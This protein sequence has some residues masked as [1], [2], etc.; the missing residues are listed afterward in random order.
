MSNYPFIFGARG[1]GG[2][3]GSVSVAL[4]DETPDLGQSVTIT[5]SVTGFTA[6]SYI[7]FAYQGTKITYIAQ[8]ASNVFVWP[9]SLNGTFDVYVFATDGTAKA[10]GS[11]QA[12]VSTVLI[13]DL[14]TPQPVAAFSL[15][16]VSLA[17]TGDGA[18]VRRSSDNAQQA[19][20]YVGQDLDISAL[21]TFVGVN[22]GFSVTLYNQF[23]FNH[24]TQSTAGSQPLFVASGVVNLING[25]PF[26]NF[27]GSYTLVFPTSVTAA[28]VFAVAR[29]ATSPNSTNEMLGGAERAFSFGLGTS[30]TGLFAFDGANVIQTSA[31]DTL[32]HQASFRCGGATG[33]IRV[34][35]VQRVTGFVNNVVV[36]RIGNRSGTPRPFYGDVSEILIYDSILS[37]ANELILEANQKTYYGL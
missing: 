37:D 4:S 21:T 24:A 7:F 14:I 13:C 27:N 6:N 20:G 3:G 22:N 28:H 25:R 30:L 31:T 1:G 33:R 16:K 12:V 34:D 11:R 35:G 2:S 29:A 36:D 26:L 23:A 32:P 19:I 17:Y 5:A 18:L 15:R 10:Y 8:Q 9:V